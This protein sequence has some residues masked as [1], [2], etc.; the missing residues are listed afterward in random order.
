MPAEKLKK[1]LD[2]SGVEYIEINHPREYTA[3]QVAAV[4]HIP[5][6]EMAKTVMIKIKDKLA[7]AVLPA[8]FRVDFHLLREVIGTDE[9]ELAREHEFQTL[10]PDC[11]IGA[12]PP[13]GN[14]YDLE[15]YVAEK[16]TEG[17]MIAF[18]ACTHTDLIR[19]SYKDYESLVKPKIIR[20]AM[21]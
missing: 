19:M 8:S 15:V 20:F 18:N 10:F 5:G 13:F 17:E 12:M 11:D 3:Q 14:L 1:Y 7:M 4:S 16:L 9:V 21:T 6:G 2:E